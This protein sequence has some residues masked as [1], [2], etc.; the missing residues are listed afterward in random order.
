[1]CRRAVND[2]FPGRMKEPLHKSGRIKWGFKM[3]KIK[4]R[5]A[6]NSP[7]IAK[8]RNAETDHFGPKLIVHDFCRGS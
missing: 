3:I 4:A 7:T 6:S 2:R 1:M 5:N 8:F